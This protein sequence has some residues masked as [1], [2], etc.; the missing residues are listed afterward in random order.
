MRSSSLLK[1]FAFILAFAGV[2]VFTSLADARGVSTFDGT[3]QRP[4]SSN[5]GSFENGNDIK[6]AAD[7][8]CCWM[9]IQNTTTSAFWS[10]NVSILGTG[11]GTEKG[12]ALRF[13]EGGST[14]TQPMILTGDVT[15]LGSATIGVQTSN[16]NSTGLISGKLKIDSSV[17]DPS[18]IEFLYRG[19]NSSQTTQRDMTGTLVLTADSS[20]FTAPIRVGSGVLQ[21]GCVGSYTATGYDWVSDGAGGEKYQQN[22]AKVFTFDGSTGSVGSTINLTSVFNSTTDFP[23]LRFQRSGS[24]TV[25]NQITGNGN[26]V[27]DGTATYKLGAVG[28]LATGLKSVTVNKGAT[29]VNNQHFGT[30][31]TWD[32]TNAVSG[33]GFYQVGYSDQA[34]ILTSNTRATLYDAL[35]ISVSNFT[36]TYVFADGYRYNLTKDW[37]VSSKGYTLGAT[38][39]GQIW[40]QGTAKYTGDLYIKG[41]GWSTSEYRGAIRFAGNYGDASEFPSVTSLTAL[42]GNLYLMGDSRIGLTADRAT[43]ALIASDLKNYGTGT[44][45]LELANSWNGSILYFTGTSG[46]NLKLNDGTTFQVGHQGTLNGTTYDGTTGS[47]GSGTVTVGGS[48]KLKFMR[49]DAVTVANTIT[50]SGRIIFDGG[51]KYTVQ[52]ALAGGTVEVTA[53]TKLTTEKG[54]TST[55]TGAGTVQLNNSGA[56]TAMPGF[57]VSNFTGTLLAGKEYRWSPAT[58]TA[59][60]VGAVDS[61]QLWLMSLADYQQKNVYLAGTG[62]SSNE[63]FGA[64]RFAGDSTVTKMAN[65][66]GTVHLLGDT[67]M[68]SRQNATGVYGMISGN[69]D[70]GTYA[71]TVDSKGSTGTIIL[72]GTNSY[73]VTN[74]NSKD[75]LVVGWIGMVNG[76]TYDGTTGTLGTGDVTIGA[77]ATLKFNRSGNVTISNALGGT[78]TVIFDGTASYTVDPAKLGS[79][80]KAVQVKENAKLT[81]TG[82]ISSDVSAKITTTNPSAP[83]TVSGSKIDVTVSEASETTPSLTF[84]K[85][86]NFQGANLLNMDFAKDFTPELGEMY[87]LFSGTTDTMNS[88]DLNTLQTVTPELPSSMF[89]AYSL[90]PYGTGLALMGTLSVPEPAA[91]VLFLVGT[92][93]LASLKKQRMNHE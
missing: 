80:L 3:K 64:L 27:F 76:K 8:N 44:Y 2:S 87:Y 89:W 46:V 33:A 82:E 77:D 66:T 49:S 23:T 12:G 37:N 18:G 50:N 59:Y 56:A 20:D 16:I 51:G 29:L 70:G 54:L 55:I 13:G 69:I 58:S 24:V 92:G 42:Y 19:A 40:M 88:L 43:V 81:L 22:T 85:N 73:G 61:G 9:F 83:L 93:L 10:N 35:P 21:L 36:G 6:I 30:T 65:V 52:N 90:Q 71:L 39:F 63:R 53:G 26:V 5:G 86:L 31:K 11:Y 15:F 14:L 67:S 57:T 62:W 17:T 4:S 47:L 75:A 32:F 7:T 38:D 41:T 68:S 72:T 28:L 60:D 79:T 48:A 74:I 34:D 45:T 78:G 91:W 1:T 25:S 84:T